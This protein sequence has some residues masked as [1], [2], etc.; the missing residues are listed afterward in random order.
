[1]KKIGLTGNIG[2]GKT[3]I[4]MIFKTLGFAVFNADIE[5]KR[6]LSDNEE[7]KQKIQDFFGEQSYDQGVLNRPYLSQLVFNDIKQL[8]FLN[9]LIHPLVHKAFHKWCQTIDSDFA[10]KEA[11]ILF[12]SGSAKE[13]DAVICVSCP[14]SLRIE[15]LLKRDSLT[16]E[17]IEKRMNSQWTEDKSL[18]DFHIL[19]DGKSLVIPQVLSIYHSLK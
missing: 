13:L 19:N 5:A 7:L 16:L 2:S 1:M 6:I 10:L 8:K 14:K 18:S 15:R 17:Q 3:T 4:S 12:E 11:A 9:S